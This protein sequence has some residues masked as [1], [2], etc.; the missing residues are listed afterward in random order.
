MSAGNPIELNLSN[1]YTV[2][3]I[4]AERTIDSV[5]RIDVGE[6]GKITKVQDR[7]NNQLPEGPISEVR[8]AIVGASQAILGVFM[9]LLFGIFCKVA[10]WWP[11][12]VG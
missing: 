6:D 12:E 10:W 5:V 1:S 11:F 7:W 4:G 3:G 8:N 9:G 2:K